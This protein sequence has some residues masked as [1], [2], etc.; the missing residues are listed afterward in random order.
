MITEK[1]ELAAGAKRKLRVV[2]ESYYDLMDVRMR[3]EHRIRNY[4]EHEGLVA[5]LGESEAEAVKLQG[6]ETYKAAIRKQREEAAFLEAYEKSVDMLEDDEHHKKVNKLMR[7][8]E[9]GLKSMAMKEVKDHPLWSEWLRYVYGIGPCLAGGLIARLKPEK[10]THCSQLWKYAGL[11]VV[12]EKW[13]CH[14]CGNEIDHHPS[15]VKGADPE[16]ASA[17]IV[18]DREPSVKCPKCQNAMAAVGHADRRV[19]GETVGYNPHVKTLFW[20]VGESFVK[21]SAAKSGYRRLYDKFRAQ[22][23]AKPCTKIHKNEKG[24]PIQCFDAHKFAKA[25][26]LTVKVFA[27]NIYTKWRQLLG[28]PVSDPFIFWKGHDRSSLVEPIYDLSPN[29]GKVADE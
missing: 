16:A 8:G 21:Q 20:K 4:A 17:A 15:L 18:R 25:K 23:D 6:M 9:A 2:I 24:E 11:S 5:V 13:H 26:R 10:W 19:K 12:V 27:A 3:T 28:L 14:A 22:V 29:D 1:E 7:Q